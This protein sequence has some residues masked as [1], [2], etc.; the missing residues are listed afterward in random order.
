MEL[1]RPRPSHMRRSPSPRAF[2]DANHSTDARDIRAG[3]NGVSVQRNTHSKIETDI[4]SVISSSENFTSKNKE[5]SDLVK[6]RLADQ[7]EKFIAE[8]EKIQEKKIRCNQEVNDIFAKLR[9]ILDEKERNVKEKVNY[10]FGTQSEEISYQISLIEEQICDLYRKD[11]A[12][13]TVDTSTLDALKAEIETRDKIISERVRSLHLNDSVVNIVQTLDLGDFEEAGLGGESEENT[14]GEAESNANANSGFGSVRDSIRLRT[15][16]QHTDFEEEEETPTNNPERLHLSHP[17]PRETN[18]DSVDGDE[19]EVD[20]TVDISTV[21]SAP[22][23]SVEDKPENPPPYWQAIG[24][25]CPEHEQE[26]ASAPVIP[27]YEE[28][29]HFRNRLPVNKLDLWHSF[30]IRRQYDSRA[31]LPAS[32][33]WNGDKIC[34]ADRANQKIKFFLPSGFQLSQ[35]LLAGNEI[36]D[37]AFLEEFNKE[38]RYLVTCPRTKTFFIIS[39]NENGRTDIVRKFK[40]PFQYG[41]VC[42]GTVEQTLIGGDSNDRYGSASVDIFNFNG[43]VIKSFKLSPGNLGLQYPKAVEVYGHFIIIMDWKLRSVMVFCHNGDVVGEYRG[44][45]ASPLCNPIDMTIDHCGNIMILDGEMSSI[46][47]IDLDCNPVEVIKIPKVFSGRT[48]ARLISFDKE[49][50]KLA[51]ARSN[52]DV[53]IFEFRNGYDGLPQRRLGFQGMGDLQPQSPRQPETLPLV[54]GMLPSTIENI[55]SR[56][57]RTRNFQ[58]HL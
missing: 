29:G 44:T 21:P 31:P 1:E 7:K 51:I 6:S 32:L 43:Q 45:P 38:A 22:P 48:S 13:V 34:L 15:N 35:V 57:N 50:K 19:D 46:H 41:C 55:V 14:D 56:N 12:G 54:E 20:L 18:I 2:P 30:P 17:H 23:L 5:E 49:T 9:H 24:L 11:E 52:G 26:G 3:P 40:S 27:N 53:V 4:D 39:C 8:K 47:V 10:E 58:F 33:T 16:L 36:Y 37:V 42:R 25:E 28:V